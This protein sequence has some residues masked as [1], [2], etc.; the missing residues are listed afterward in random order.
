ML[1]LNFYHFQIA[2]QQSISLQRYHVLPVEGVGIVLY[3][4]FPKRPIP[5]HPLHKFSRCWASRAKLNVFIESIM[6]VLRRWCHRA[7]LFRTH[8]VRVL[9]A[10]R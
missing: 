1:S 4:P 7:I 8:K 2:V 6:I 5:R 9:E 3:H 10:A